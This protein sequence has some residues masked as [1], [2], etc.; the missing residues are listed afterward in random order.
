MS[1]NVPHESSDLLRPLAGIAPSGS[2]TVLLDRAEKV[3]RDS[4]FLENRFYHSKRA[5]GDNNTCRNLLPSFSVEKVY[6]GKFVV[7][8]NK[9][10]LGAIHPYPLRNAD[11][12]T[13]RWRNGAQF[14]QLPHIQNVALIVNA[15][16]KGVEVV[17]NL[18][19][20]G[21]IEP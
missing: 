20:V 1:S 21:R 13:P 7:K 2:Q 9:P 15:K 8:R 4:F 11:P 6:C 18:E 16:V 12:S 17:T 19:F 14:I 10:T 5:I 3:E